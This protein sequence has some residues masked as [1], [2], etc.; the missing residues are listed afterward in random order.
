MHRALARQCGALSIAASLFIAGTARAAVIEGHVHDAES[1]L[2][3]PWVDLVIEGT[4]WATMSDGHGAF[5]LRN[6]DA[7]DH[8]LTAR[9]IGYDRRSMSLHV[10]ATDTVRVEVVLAPRPVALEVHEVSGSAL[11]HERDLYEGQTPVLLAGRD[12]RER[13]SGTVAGVLAD[14]PGISEESMGPAP[15]RPVVR[16]LSGNR[17]LVLEDQVTTGDLSGTAPDHALVV[18]PLNAERIEVLRGPATL[19]YGASVLGGV[20][21]VRRDAVP[22]VRRTR[23][24]G[25][26]QVIGDSVNRSSAGNLNLVGPLGPFAYSLD[27]V[28]RSADDVST[29]AG[30]MRNTQIDT[31]NGSA[32]LGW[33]G[34][35]AHFGIAGSLYESDYGIP[36]GFLGGHPN[37]VDIELERRRLQVRA[38]LHLGR[39]PVE[40]W[41][42]QGAYVRYFHRENESSGICGVSF[43]LLTH[44][45]D[46][47]LHLRRGPWGSP[48]LGLS[49]QSR[50]YAQGCLTFVPPTIERTYALAAYDEFRTGPVRWVAGLRGEYR[51]IDTSTET[52][53]KAGRIRDRD[54]AGMGA[55]LSATVDLAASLET[56]LTLTRAFRAPALEELFSEGPHLASYA[57][58]VGNADLGVENGNGIELGL[59][60]RPRSVHVALT[61]F[62]NRFDG[63]IH[64]VDTGDLEFGPGAEGF[65]QRWQYRGRDARL[66]GGEFDLMWRPT[67][68]WE[69]MASLAAVQGTD[70]DEDRALPRMPPLTGRIGTRIRT[71]SLG[72]TVNWRGATAQRRVAEFEETSAGWSTLG[73]SV[74]W[75][76]LTEDRH[77]SIVLRVDNLTDAEIRNHLSRIRSILP[78]PGRNVTLLYRVGFF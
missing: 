45:L 10:G 16:G 14:Q 20:V 31:W 21:N 35:R 17:L 60:W 48:V 23:T 63:Y 75:S 64:P 25:A 22:M 6:V 49:V 76:R 41:E 47:R 70:L 66:V 30:P 58:E 24:E 54:F 7:G 18:D 12:L 43:G 69:W 11:E 50:D 34:E 73:A 74:Q 40:R 62:W 68:R 2:P 46:Q 72:W 33:M 71:G 3:V 65:L 4:T 61:G 78:E 8:R 27:V 39:G 42:A 9:R 26:L 38:G 1:G 56:K 36:G 55:S 13:M 15:A 57:Y 53:N 77:Q 67:Q 44:A 32:G 51:E 28:G 59:R 19:L 29:P 5:V 37:G 52:T